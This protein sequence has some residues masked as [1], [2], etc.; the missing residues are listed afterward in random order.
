M[1]IAVSSI[2]AGFVRAQSHAKALRASNVELQTGRDAL[3]QQTLELERR[4][5]YLEATVS[6]ARDVATIQEP[7]TLLARVVRLISEQFGF[8]HAGAFLLDSTRQWAVLQAASSEGG[9]RMLARGHR[10][11]VGQQGTV[12]Y[13]TSHGE[14]RIALDVGEDA[15]FFNNPDLPE[16]RSAATLPL[17]VYDEIIGALDVQS[18]EQ[19]AFSDEDAEVLQSL[20][21]QVALAIN[22][23]N[24]FLRA[25]ESAEA[26][27]RA[28]GEITREMWT[29]LLRQESELGYLSNAQGIFPAGDAWR[30]EMASAIRAAKIVM[31]EQDKTRLAI[32]LEVSGQVI[33]VLDG[34]KAQGWTADEIATVQALVEQLNAAV[35]RARLYRETQ[36]RA[37]REGAIREISDEMQRATDMGSLLRITAEALNRTLRG[38][39][40][41]VSMGESDQPEAVDLS[42]G[43]G[44]S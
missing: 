38:S 21:D 28:R 2:S 36:R 42:V 18:K 3:I 15:V 33:G 31:D 5:R 37:A 4:A 26:E 10:L 19:A 13:V 6:V 25:Q 9:Q 43:E 34:Y 29:R 12:G 14:P 11:R 7:Q 32:P 27:R 22:N 39:R 40:V 1:H 35:E 44:E 16:T 20:A 8:Y 17:H 41:Y 24:L 30:P 23:A